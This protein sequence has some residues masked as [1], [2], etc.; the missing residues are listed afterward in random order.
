MVSISLKRLC[1]AGAML[2]ASAATAMAGDL[3][4]PPWRGDPLSTYQVWGMG[5][6]DPIPQPPDQ[7]F[8]NPSLTGPVFMDLQGAMGMLPN[9]LPEVTTSTGVGSGVWCLWPQEALYFSI[10]NY[11]NHNPFKYVRLQ[12]KVFNPSAPPGTTGDLRV[13]VTGDFLGAS[14]DFT[15]FQPLPNGFVN[16]TVDIFLEPN[17]SFEVIYIRNIKN[18]Q[19]YI[20]QVVIDTICVPGAPAFG[21]AGIVGLAAFRRRRA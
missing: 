21:L 1:A 17:P 9:W 10:P 18:S 3:N 12:F 6:P 15:G 16:V 13:E 5:Q 11:D 14:G 19:I 20:D 2:F 8:Q 4:P 7:L